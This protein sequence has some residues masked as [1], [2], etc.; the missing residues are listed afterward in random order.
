[1]IWCQAATSEL[2]LTT[3]TIK[4]VLL[5]QTDKASLVPS[6]MQADHSRIRICPLDPS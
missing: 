4:P 6:L 2:G 5:M 1:M 3:F